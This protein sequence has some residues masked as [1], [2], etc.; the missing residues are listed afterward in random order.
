MSRIQIGE[1]LHAIL[2]PVSLH[3][4]TARLDNHVFPFLFN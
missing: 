2:L 3:L 4:S 1:Y